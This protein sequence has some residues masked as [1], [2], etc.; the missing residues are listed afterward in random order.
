MHWMNYCIYKNY[1]SHHSQNETEIPPLVPLREIHAKKNT[2][3]FVNVYI[4]LCLFGTLLAT[5][6]EAERSL[7]KLGNLL[8]TWK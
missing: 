5:V 7:N 3:R 4:A 1:T 8:K 6:S 2:G